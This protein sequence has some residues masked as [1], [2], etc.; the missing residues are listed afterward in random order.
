MEAIKIKLTETN[1]N[2]EDKAT[3]IRYELIVAYA[4]KT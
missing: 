1:N 4:R 3:S 2:F